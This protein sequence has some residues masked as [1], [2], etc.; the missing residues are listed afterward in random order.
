MNIPI[1]HRAPEYPG[2]SY[3]NFEGIYCRAL[4]I[5]ATDSSE[6]PV[7]LY[8]TMVSRLKRQY[9]AS[10]FRAEVQTT[11]FSVYLAKIQ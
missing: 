5:E 10:I 4:K 6:M 9:A 2:N 3:Q 11:D 1:M 7:T 8:H